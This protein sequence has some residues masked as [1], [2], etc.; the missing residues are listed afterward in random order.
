MTAVFCPD[1]EANLLQ[2]KFTKYTVDQNELL[3]IEDFAFA[4]ISEIQAL[5]GATIAEYSYA[6]RPMSC[7][8]CKFQRLCVR[9]SNV[10]PSSESVPDL[11][12]SATEL[13]VSSSGSEKLAAKHN[14]F[15][16]SGAAGHNGSKG[17]S[18]SSFNFS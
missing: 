6:D 12:S 17:E 16:E 2:R 18:Q 4:S 11:Q 5:S 7:E 15:G 13:Q 10:E 14:V 1:C 8:F 3:K 9:L